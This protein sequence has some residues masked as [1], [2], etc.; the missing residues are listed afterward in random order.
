[1]P[2]T[3]SHSSSP[4]DSPSRE[5]GRPLAG[6]RRQTALGEYLTDS[7]VSP[8]RKYQ[9][10]VV[11]ERGF[12][13]F[14][15]Y[16]GLTTLL[17]GLPGVAGLGLRRLL[18][19]SLL[20][21]AGR[22]VV[23]GKGITL[24]HPGLIR[25]GPDVVIDDGCVLDAKGSGHQGI[26]VGAGVFISRSTVLSCKGGSIE[27]GDHVNLG[28]GCVVLS[29]SRVAIGDS[30]LFAAHCYLVAGGNHDFSRTDIP[31]I[32]QPSVSR[33]G[34]TIEQNVWLGARVTVLDGVT[35]GRDSVVGAGAVV[36]RDIPPFSIAAGVPARVTR[37]RLGPGR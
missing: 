27:L 19:P 34:I 35:I 24:R 26:T 20:A 3:V 9:D 15:R 31:I 8:L 5:A 21:A 28:I 1:M 2:D 30:C 18:Y 16:E 13:R 11:G 32:Q 33:G 36:T 17:G 12:L 6:P 4:E 25:V 10:L 29:E 23:F 14:L 7:T 37:S 22:N